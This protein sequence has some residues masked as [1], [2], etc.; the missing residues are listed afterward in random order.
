VIE[1]KR[2]ER[3]GKKNDRYAD[4]YGVGNLHYTEMAIESQKI[5]IG[6]Q[7]DMADV[8]SWLTIA[9]N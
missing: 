4:W 6:R 3:S 1:N 2:S 8:F 9:Y 5:T 7:M